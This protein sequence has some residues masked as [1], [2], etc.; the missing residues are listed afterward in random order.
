MVPTDEL[1]CSTYALK[2]GAVSEAMNKTTEI[3]NTSLTPTQ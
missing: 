3:E 1:I 2:E